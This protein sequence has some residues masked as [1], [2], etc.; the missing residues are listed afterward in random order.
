MSHNITDFLRDSKRCQASFDPRFAQISTLPRRTPKVS[1]WV[2]RSGIELFRPRSQTPLRSV[3]SSLRSDFGYAQ[4]DTDEKAPSNARWDLGGALL[5]MTRKRVAKNQPYTVTEPFFNAIFKRRYALR[6][7]W[8]CVV[9]CFY[10]LGV[11]KIFLKVSTQMIVLRLQQGLFSMP[12]RLLQHN[13]NYWIIHLFLTVCFSIFLAKYL[14]FIWFFITHVVFSQ[15][16]VSFYCYVWVSLFNSVGYANL[17]FV[18]PTTKP[19]SEA[20]YMC[21]FLQ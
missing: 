4:D 3:W 8:F 21:C 5:R 10:L 9:F 18:Y 19:I 6:G 17:K 1:S 13:A 11:K 16:I 12:N 2:E 15:A 7:N 14:F 20:L